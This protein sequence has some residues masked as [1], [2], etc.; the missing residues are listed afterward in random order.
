VAQPR[1][2]WLGALKLIGERMASASQ[3]VLDK[4]SQRLDFAVTRLGRPSTRVAR[5]R[6][7]LSRHSQQLRHAV[8]TRLEQSNA[9]W[10]WVSA[11]FPK[12]VQRHLQRE[13]ERLDRTGLRLQAVDP[14]RVLRRGYAWLSD[15]EGHAITSAQGLL[16]GQPVR[17]TLADGTVDLTVTQ[18]RLL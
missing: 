15:T 3:R 10:R 2:T 17:A 4:Q 1:E 7:E 5:Q 8:L 6:L 18:Q 9:S 11:E 13:R 14:H 12:K 16:A